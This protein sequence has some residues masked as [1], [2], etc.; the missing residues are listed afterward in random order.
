MTERM[1]L[2]PIQL[3]DV[4]MPTEAGIDA[5]FGERTI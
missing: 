3:T 1:G 4:E 2:P 5:S